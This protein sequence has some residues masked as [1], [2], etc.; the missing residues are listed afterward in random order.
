MDNLRRRS[1]AQKSIID[2]ITGR[3]TIDGYE[4]VDLGLPSGVLWT[5]CNIGAETETGYGRYYRWGATLPYKDPSYYSVGSND[6]SSEYDTAYNVMGSGWRMPTQ[7]EMQELIDNTDYSWVTGNVNCG[8]FTSKNNQ[9]AY[10]LFPASGL[11]EYGS[12]TISLISQYAYAWSSTYGGCYNQ[13]NYGY[14]LVLNASACYCNTG[15][16]TNYVPVRGVH[17]SI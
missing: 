5:T 12:A 3:G 4:V 7:A 10:I 2:P 15:K 11:R 17:D 13:N 6:L 1:S 9:N 16:G 14:I 8:K